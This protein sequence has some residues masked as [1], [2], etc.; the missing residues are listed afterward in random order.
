MMIQAAATPVSECKK[1][2]KCDVLLSE[3]GEVV[4]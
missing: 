4:L 1:S 3:I 2:M